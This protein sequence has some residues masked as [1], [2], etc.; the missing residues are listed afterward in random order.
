[1]GDVPTLWAIM[2][3]HS[4]LCF[5]W[6]ESRQYPRTD[7]SNNSVPPTPPHH[8]HHDRTHGQERIKLNT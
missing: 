8:H 6:R 7:T 3:C 5:A 2:T 1:M 4:V